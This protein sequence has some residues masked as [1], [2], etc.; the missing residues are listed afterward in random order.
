M[1]MGFKYQMLACKSP[2]ELFTVTMNHLTQLRSKVDE[3][4]SVTD[5][6]DQVILLTTNKYKS[7]PCADFAGLK[8][9][10]CRFF[11]DKKVKVSLFL[12]DGIQKQDGAI[13][14]SNRGVMP[15]GVGVPGQIT[16]FDQSG[17][18]ASVDSFVFPGVEQL[19]PAPSNAPWV[20]VS[21][22]LGLNLYAKDVCTSVATAASAAAVAAAAAQAEA[23]IASPLPAKLDSTA[24]ER[25]ILSGECAQH[26]TKGLNLLA[27]LIGAGASAT[28]TENFKLNLF[29]DT[30]IE[31]VA[32]GKGGNSVPLIT[33][34]TGSQALHASNKHL[35][36]IMDDMRIDTS[37][38]AGEDDLLGLMDAA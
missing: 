28:A 30:N 31:S 11:S 10:L 4:K 13:V 35:V 17:N 9:A 5:L 38:N 6:V 7:M 20:P 37:G 32:S 29:P 21:S 16:H 24:A 1:T 34:D 15:P 3:A 8:Q 22:Q 33:I 23:Q 19:E 2:Q 36:G 26:S 14:L 27:E 18:S 12:Q 25:D